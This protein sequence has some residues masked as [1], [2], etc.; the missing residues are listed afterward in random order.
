LAKSHYSVKKRQKEANR[1][2]KQAQKRQRKQEKGKDNPE[3]NLGE[4]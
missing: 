2:L 3:N 1:K 4:D